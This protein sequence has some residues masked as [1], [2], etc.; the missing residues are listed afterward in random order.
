MKHT[1]THLVGGLNPSEKY[2]GQLGWLF[3][4][5]GKIKLMFQT[6][7][8]MK[9]THTHT[10]AL[11]HLEIL[12]TQ[13]WEPRDFTD[14]AHHALL[15]SGHARSDVFLHLKIWINSTLYV[16]FQQKGS[17][18]DF[19]QLKEYVSNVSNFI[20]L[21]GFPMIFR[22][23]LALFSR[24]FFA[25]MPPQSTVPQPRGIGAPRKNFG[26][27]RETRLKGLVEGKIMDNLQETMNF[28]WIFL[29]KSMVFTMV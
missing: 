6:T 2:E 20:S 19:Y 24:D 14:F 13:R 26:G 25:L 22:L 5:Y 17:Y 11:L 23:F 7:N 8:Q 15:S 28:P 12:K 18:L 29:W 4:I 1:H 3:P 9:H 16:R 27:L 10:H 21:C